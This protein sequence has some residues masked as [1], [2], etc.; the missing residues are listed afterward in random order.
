MLPE[1]NYKGMLNVNNLSIDEDK[2][3]SKPIKVVL[4]GAGNRTTIYGSYTE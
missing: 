1:G 4:V 2:D 3:Q